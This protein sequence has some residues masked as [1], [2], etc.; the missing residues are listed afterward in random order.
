MLL[1]KMA[2]GTHEVAHTTAIDAIR[3]QLVGMGL[4]TQVYRTETTR[5]DSIHSNGAAKEPDDG[6]APAKF[7][8]AYGK[9]PTFVIE[10][11]D[12]QPLQNAL[13]AKD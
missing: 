5:N 1:V 4:A 12:T 9:F 10:D 8:L 7:R 3:D 13:E 11:A 6:L 2:G